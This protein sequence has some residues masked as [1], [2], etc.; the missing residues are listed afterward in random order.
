MITCILKYGLCAFI[1]ILLGIFCPGS[2]EAQEAEETYSI[3]LTKTAG[4]EEDIYEVDNKK[5]LTE[6]Y[7]IKEGEWVWQILRQKGLLE[8]RN[9]SE[10]LTVLQALNASL[11]RLDLVHPGEKIIIPLKIAPVAG[12]SVIAASRPPVKVSL[13][14][15]KDVDLENYT[16]ESGDS[17]SRII[18]GRYDIPK[19]YLYGEYLGMIRKLNPSIRD[20]DIIH[21]GQKIKLPVYTPEIVRKPIKMARPQEAEEKKEGVK[22]VKIKSGLSDAL[23]V[24]FTEMGEEWVKTGE[25]FIPLKSGSQ[26]D[27]KAVSF[28]IL[29]LQNGLRVMVD[30]NNKLPDKMATLIE[31][32]WGN[33]RVLHLM[34]GDT[35]RAALDKILG[36][37]N[38]PKVSRKGEALELG[39]DISIRITADWIVKL[40]EK[41]SDNRPG[42][43]VI[44]L[45]EDPVKNTPWMIKEY[46]SRLGVKVIDYPR[47]DD[48]RTEVAGNSATLKGGGEPA[49]LAKALLDLTGRSYSTQVEIPVYQKQKADFKLI[50]KADFFLKSRGKDAIIDLIGLAPEMV[51]LLEEHQ[52]LVLSMANEKD[53]LAVVSMTLEFL[54]IE[55]QK[56]PH[57]FMAGTGDESRHVKLTLPGVVFSDS[58]GNPVLATPLSLPEEIAAFLSKQAYRI[59][60]LSFT[61]GT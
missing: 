33:Y 17:L 28:P 34:E 37:C 4:I 1:T 48:K 12:A 35:L 40:S 8:Q 21:P 16:V 13:E 19:D 6:E 30:L 47:G 49:S 60:P 32:S 56:G 15:L 20:L 53:P 51:S 25:H 38:Y 43:A 10:I 42:F 18:K 59:L 5:V 29:N 39:G 23:H 55:Y 45:D 9:L 22:E 3:S 36:V 41:Q 44:N 61:T 31:S 27:L 52:F 50:I 26:I 46:L 14:D 24:I 11:G 2:P 7:I 54:D 57:S 58:R